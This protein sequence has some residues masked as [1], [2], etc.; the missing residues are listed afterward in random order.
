MWCCSGSIGVTSYVV[1][2]WQFLCDVYVVLSG[3]IGVTLYVVLEWQYW[4]DVCGVEWRY[5]CDVVCGVGV[6]V[7]V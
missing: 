5:W 6:A 7:L 3:G 4:C 1:L 2:E